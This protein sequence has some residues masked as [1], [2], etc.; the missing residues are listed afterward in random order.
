MLKLATLLDNPGEPRAESRYRD[1]NHLAELGYNGR[2]IYSTTALSGVDRP[3]SVG[4]GEMRRWVEQQFER[5]EQS[6]E[7][8]RAAGLDVYITY[9]VL[10]LPRQMVERDE[11]ALTCKGRPDVICPASETAIRRS[12]DALRA[13]LER[14]PTLAGVVLRVGDNDAARLPYLVGNEVYQPHCARCSQL[15]RVDRV[16]NVLTRF[17]KLVVEDFD[18]RLIARAWNVRPNGMHDSVDVC[19]GLYPKL[20]GKEDDDRFVISFKFTETDFWRYQRWNPSSLCLGNRPVLYE[21]QCQRE[22][23]GKGGVPNWQPPLWLHGAPEVGEEHFG[24]SEARKRVNLAGLWAWV[25]GGGWGGPFVKN[26]TWIDANVFAVPLIADQPDIDL[27]TLANRWIKHR[28]PDLSDRATQAVESLLEHSTQFALDGFYI[29]PFAKTRDSAWH[30]NGDLIQDDII[31]A[32]AA[33]RMVQRLP[34]SELDNVVAEKQRAVDQIARNLS[35]LHK[36]AAEEKHAAL[37]PMINTLEYTESLFT[38]LRDLLA[39]VIAYRRHQ[40]APNDQRRDQVRRLIRSSQT[41]WTH[42]T[43]RHGALPGAATAFRESHFWDIT[44]RILEE[45]E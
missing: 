32:D 18:K 28:L 9:D 3:D 30:P 14:W 13:L 12:V 42:H 29:G 20:P 43:Q 6:I 35:T 1:P 8:S 33:L 41:Q 22:F 27:P 31:D 19:E 5:H 15:G 44:Q 21:L 24:L 38:A 25:R 34:E 11:A 37:E 45:T 2:V 17:H 40:K 23:E 10:S 39:G 26:E 16:A 36:L 7:E 4:T